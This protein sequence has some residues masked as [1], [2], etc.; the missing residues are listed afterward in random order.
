MNAKMEKAA[1]D[2]KK[3]DSLM[4]A[5]ESSYLD[6]DVKGF[7][8]K[9]YDRFVS[10]FYLLWDCINQVRDDIDEIIGDETVVN[11]IYAVNDVNRQKNS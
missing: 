3:M 5:I 6:E 7:D 9:R 10:S 11:A 4:Y 1:T 8:F 2:I